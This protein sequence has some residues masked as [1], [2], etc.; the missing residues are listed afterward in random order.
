MRTRRG[1]GV[2]E[3]ERR[4]IIR[5]MDHAR[6]LLA[7]AIVFAGASLGCSRQTVTEPPKTEVPASAVRVSRPD[8]D[9]SEPTIAALPNGKFLVGYVEKD[10]SGKGDLYIRSFEAPN[11]LGE[12]VRVNPEPGQ[13]KTW[14]G[15]PPTMVVAAD[16]TVYVGWTARYPDSKKGTLLY[17]ST[18]RDG[19]ATFDA[20]VKVHS[21]T[22]PAAHGMHSLAVAPDGRIIAAWLDE[23]YLLD[24]KP[25]SDADGHHNTSVS[26]SPSS[27]EES[28]PNAELY[29]SVSTDG[30]KT[31]AP[32]RRIDRDV[33]PCC[34]TSLAIGNDGTVYLGYRRVYTGSFRH[35]TLATSKDLQTFTEPVQV[36]DDR[37][38]LEACPVSGPALK[39]DN[40]RLAIGW[41]SG[42]EAREHGLYLTHAATPVARTFD[43]PQKLDTFEGGGTP[44]W[45]GHGL[46]WS[47][48]GTIRDSKTSPPTTLAQ[49]R[50]IAA[51]ENAYAYVS[52]AEPNKSVW[53]NL[54]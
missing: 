54:R 15:D 52:T 53:L 19:G 10:D 45:A 20:P 6:K 37:W 14:Y 9:A 32:D 36:S 1:E 28:E 3:D 4:A 34:K 27:N 13:V 22:A 44:A 7:V 42:G 39:I 11:A 18:S 29:F 31:F 50:N 26:A 43:A 24:A 40:G 16:G 38:Q 12:P 30:A 51:A 21:D 5:D 47:S 46:L 35:I 49:G 25:H 41:Y 33:C 23:R 8:V 48:D 2:R 17:V